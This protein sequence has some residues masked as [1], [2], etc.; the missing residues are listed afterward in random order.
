MANMENRIVIGLGNTGNNIV[1]EI[2]NRASLDDVSLYA[3]DSVA[4]SISMENVSRI[5]NI[6]IISD[7]KSGSGRNR[8]RGQAMFEYH[9]SKGAFDEL[10]EAAVNAKSPVI[11][12]TSSA[13]GTGSGS[14]VPLY[15]KLTE[16]NIKAIPIIVIP[17]LQDPNAYH[18][19]TNDLFAELGEISDK[20]EADLTYATFRNIKNSADYTNINNDIV[21]FIEIL[22]GKYYGETSL[23]S[24]DDSD[25]DNILNMPGR[26]LAAHAIAPDANRLAKAISTKVF[27]G[28]QPA[29]SAEEA[30]SLTMMKAYSLKSMFADSDFEI[31]FKNINDRIDDYIDEFRNL[32]VDDNDGKA[33]ATAII[34]GLPRPEIKDVTFKYNG[35]KNVSEGINK[36]ARP[37]FMNRKKAHIVKEKS[38]DGTTSIDKFKW[39]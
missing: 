9:E 6:P 23:D 8:E 11:I 12:V 27:S 19:N 22:F 35:A 24:I 33:E 1:K 29:W 7:D 30:E 13:G 39:N 36:S 16:M 31:V 38:E 34:A 10:Y 2:A 3:I 21:T 14:C 32:E 28:F 15:R 37:S 5:T 26:L 18:M 4:S 20:L 17:S 25:L